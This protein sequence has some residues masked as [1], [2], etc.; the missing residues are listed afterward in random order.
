[1]KYMKYFL[2]ACLFLFLSVKSKAQEEQY[3][4]EMITER[5]DETE[6]PRL[7]SKGFLQ[8]ETG[9]FYKEFSGD[10][11]EDLTRGY[12][13]SLLRYGLLENLELRIGADLINREENFN[14]PE[15]QNSTGLTPLMLGAKIGITEENGALPEI[16]FMGHLHLPFIAA[17]DYRPETV[18]VD[19]RFAFT[20][21]FS[22]ADL[23]YNVGAQWLEDSPEA[24]F[25]YTI[26]YGFAITEN[27]GAFA[28]LYGELP[29]DDSADYFWD[30]GI[31]YNLRRNIQLD[32]FVGS[33]F[34]NSQKIYLGAG[35]SFRI[36]E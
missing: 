18:G 33:G 34:N 32:A 10:V 21:S 23:T 17:R 9:F 19:F 3:P 24:T 31:T 22:D 29:E 1:M 16:G 5:P 6:A 11:S 4:E 2:A 28:E 27:L 13:T 30:A 20:H 26:S 25:I 12:N 7:V 8:V 15:A 36:P 14:G 35:I